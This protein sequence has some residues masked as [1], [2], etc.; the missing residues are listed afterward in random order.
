[1]QAFVGRQRMVGTSAVADEIPTFCPFLDVKYLDRQHGCVFEYETTVLDPYLL[2]LG[3]ER[4]PRC[5]YRL[6][7]TRE[8]RDREPRKAP[9]AIDEP[10]SELT[11][12]ADH[13]KMFDRT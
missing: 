11:D 2:E 4:E 7:E 1:M 6:S 3:S 13:R 12:T 8:I 5:F 9:S 10:W